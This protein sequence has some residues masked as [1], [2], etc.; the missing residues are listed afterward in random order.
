MQVPG[1]SAILYR[2]KQVVRG[3]AV[4]IALLVAAASMVQSAG[5]APT[6]PRDAV[7]VEFY[8]LGRDRRPIADLKAEE[9]TLKV[10]GRTRKISS[11]QLVSVAPAPAVDPTTPTP[12]ETP[13]PFAT[14][15]VAE[16]G[17]TFIMVFDDE[18]IRP[19][20]EQPLRAA[21]GRFLG[22]LTPRDRVSLLT[23]PHGGMK[24]DLTTNHDRISQAFSLL[25]G[26]APERETGSEGAC[27]TRT[28]LESLEGMLGSLAGG[29][30]PTTIIFISATEFG[31]RRDA[32][33]T[34][35]PGMCELTTRVFERMGAAAAPARAHFWVVQP[36]QMMIRGNASNETIAGTNFTGSDNPLEGLEHIAGVTAAERLSLATAGDATLIQIAQQTTAYYSAVLETT[37]ADL[38]GINRGLDVKVS[39]GGH[40]VRARPHVYLPRPSTARPATKTPADMMK[41]SQLSHDLPLRATGYASL[42]S[43]DGAS[44]KVIAVS[45][46]IDPTVKITALAAG[47]FDGQGRLTRMVSAT[48]DQLTSM[49]VMAALLVP[50][51]TYR[52]RVAAV[53]ASGRSGSVDTEVSAE[54]TPAG[55][56]KLSSLVAGLSRAGGFVPRMQFGNEP[57]AIGF[58]EIYGGVAGA[59]VGAAVEVARTPSGPPL[60]VT[61]LAIEPTGDPTTFRAS[62]AIPIG[63]LPPGDYVI[64]ALVGVQDQPFG[65][66]VKTIRKVAQ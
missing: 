31:P 20:R 52:M 59:A 15:T 12:E 6:S 22:S 45:E 41:E 37:A 29:K 40:Q 65:R 47:L 58:L 26:H 64:R 7:A 8:V 4:S 35:A 30:G 16:T 27:R 14:N 23:V 50:P 21:V 43:S 57:V 46:P 36:E 28:V 54:M 66:V 61:R 55:P 53:D 63:A 39:R 1:Q 51:G 49:P 3:V 17:R 13:P 56:L 9:V 42:G 11:L 5:Q 38:D 18:S 34:L 44:M 2:M 60:V 48:G 24:V 10:D 33:A 32:P 25:T 62:G 19:G